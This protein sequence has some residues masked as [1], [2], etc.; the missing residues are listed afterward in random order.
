MFTGKV[1]GNN[2]V[3]EHRLQS[4]MTIVSYWLLPV[5]NGALGAIIFCLTWMLKD[6]LRAPKSGEIIL[7]MVFGGFAD[8]LIATLFL[9]S[10]VPLGP[11]A[12]SAPGVSLLAFIFG[13]SLDSFIMVLERLNRLVMDS[14]RPKDPEG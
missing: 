10:G 13:F 6:K 11:Y 4:G 1:L 12:G 14:T 5:L 3:L 2:L 7:R 9:P 8:L